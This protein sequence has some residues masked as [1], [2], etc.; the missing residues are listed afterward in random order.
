MTT[1]YTA[2]LADRGVVSITGPDAAKLLQ[3]LITND[4]ALLEQAP[5]IHAAL[6]TPQGKIMFD[7][8]VVGT[9]QG[10]W[11][12]TSREIAPSLTKRIAMYRLRAN[13]EITDVSAVYDVLAVWD[14]AGDADAADIG[15]AVY[16]D[17]RLAALGARVVAPAGTVNTNASAE[18]YHAHRIALGAPEG[19]KDYTFG[20]TYP[21]EADF[22]LLSG[23]SFTKGCYVGQEVVARMQNKM[24]VRKRVVKVRG[25]SDLTPHADVLLGEAAVGR[26]GTTAGADALAMLRLDR[27]L[28]AR[29]QAKALL[30]NGVTVTPDE[31]AL[32]AFE[33]AA[34]AARYGASGA[35]S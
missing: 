17:P 26:I 14:G 11:L 30:A 31:T 22:D 32:A 7:F 24:V 2:L 21:H 27:A 1:A 33:E 13:A 15:A 34:S 4:M 12:E 23:V 6:L 16:Q 25:S 8:F 5:A 28:E 10:L 29:E 35:L 9:A 18:S 3:G 19:G 20:D